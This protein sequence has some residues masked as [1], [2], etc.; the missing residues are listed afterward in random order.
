MG[1]LQKSKAAKSGK[2]ALKQEGGSKEGREQSW[3]KGKKNNNTE[4]E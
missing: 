4:M 1:R 3:E 2:Q